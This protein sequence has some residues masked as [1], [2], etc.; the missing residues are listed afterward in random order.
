MMTVATEQRMAEP[1]STKTAHNSP[2]VKASFPSTATMQKMMIKIAGRDRDREWERELCLSHFSSPHRY[3][4]L[5]PKPAE[6]E[7][8]CL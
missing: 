8:L 4:Q 1:V 3:P 5:S 2:F 7:A 6:R